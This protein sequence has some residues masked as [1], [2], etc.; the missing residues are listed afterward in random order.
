MKDSEYV[1]VGSLRL[2]PTDATEYRRLVSIEEL[3]KQAA[4]AIGDLRTAKR[5]RQRIG[6]LYELYKTKSVAEETYK[7]IRELT[8]EQRVA[9]LEKLLGVQR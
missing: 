9:H 1:Y 8:L 3:C 4:I 5:A 7:G 6:G 2:T